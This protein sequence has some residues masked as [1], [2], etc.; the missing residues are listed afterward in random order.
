MYADEAHR[1]AEAALGELLSRRLAVEA[2]GVPADLRCW[3]EQLEFALTV[4][5]S[6]STRA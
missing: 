3:A 4:V 2:T 1:S 5:Q 6:A